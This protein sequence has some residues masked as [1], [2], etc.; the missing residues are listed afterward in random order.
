MNDETAIDNSYMNAWLRCGLGMEPE[1]ES[2]EDQQEEPTQGWDGGA[3]ETVNP[4][5]GNAYMNRL[6]RQRG[7][8]E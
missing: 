8:Y 2:K 4:F 3:R 1:P 6:L 7:G 5:D